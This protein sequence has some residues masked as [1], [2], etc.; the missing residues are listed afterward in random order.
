MLWQITTFCDIFTFFSKNKILW[1][2]TIFYN[3]FSILRQIDI[4]YDMIWHWDM[5]DLDHHPVHPLVFCRAC[6][7]SPLTNWHRHRQ[8]CIVASCISPHVCMYVCIAFPLGWIIYVTPEW[9]YLVTSKYQ[10]W[11]FFYFVLQGVLEMHIVFLRSSKSKHKV[12]SSATQSSMFGAAA[13]AAQMFGSMIS[14]PPPHP[15][16]MQKK[17]PLTDSRTRKPKNKG[18]CHLPNSGCGAHSKQ[19]CPFFFHSRPPWLVWVAGVYYCWVSKAK[20]L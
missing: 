7:R 2:F 19:W 20:W 12:G 17:V 3:L 1:H 10:I 8:P 6:L 16:D 13:R 4:W 5:E 15:W 9:G 18:G 14:L 11:F